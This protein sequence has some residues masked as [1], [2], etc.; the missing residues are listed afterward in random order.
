MDFKINKIQIRNRNMVNN[1]MDIS[2]DIQIVGLAQAEL[3]VI[4]LIISNRDYF[5]HQSVALE[6][7]RQVHTLNNNMLCLKIIN[8]IKMVFIIR[9][10]I[11]ISLMQLEKLSIIYK[12]KIVIFK[13]LQEKP[14]KKQ[15]TKILFSYIIVKI[16]K[17]VS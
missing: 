15:Q 1:K 5:Y 12:M 13:M 2:K 3:L 16:E 11:G 9:K 14:F 17:K 4:N 7:I 10:K 8:F 6:I